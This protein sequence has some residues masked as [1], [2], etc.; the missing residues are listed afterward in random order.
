[1]LKISWTDDVSNERMLTI[2]DIKY[3]VLLTIRKENDVF[4]HVM[5]RNVVDSLSLT[6]KVEGK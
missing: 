2:A 6:G 1:M 5:T 4:G 3:D